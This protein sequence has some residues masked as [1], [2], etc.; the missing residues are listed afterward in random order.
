MFRRETAMTECA[1]NAHVL[2]DRAAKKPA[3]IPQTRQ[4]AYVLLEMI[5]ALTVFAVVVSGLAQALHSSLDA[6]NLLRGSRDRHGLE[7]ILN[8]AKAKPK[9]EEKAMTY[10]DDG[11]GIEVPIRIG[12]AEMDQRDGGRSRASTFCSVARHGCAASKP[13]KGHGEVYFTA[14]ETDPNHAHCRRGM[15]LN[16][17]VLALQAILRSFRWAI[18]GIVSGSVEA[19]AS[20]GFKFQS[21]DRRVETFPTIGTRTAFAHLPAGAPLELKDTGK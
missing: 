7:S 19:T 13:I 3:L 18:Y 8:E 14:L 1:H 5:I 11:L 10:R 6:A 15:T 21:E 17:V 4:G 16:E 12:G 2:P 20:L 9:R